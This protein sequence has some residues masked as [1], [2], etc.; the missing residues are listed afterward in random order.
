MSWI[1]TIGIFL[2]G[3]FQTLN[4]PARL[5]MKED[6][7]EDRA[8]VI[9]QKNRKKAARQERKADRQERKTERKK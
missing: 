3:L 2:K 9:K 6:K 5:E 7:R 1:K 8:E 4:N